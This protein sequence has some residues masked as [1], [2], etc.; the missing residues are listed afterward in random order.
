MSKIEDGIS[1]I[2]INI[3]LEWKFIKETTLESA[4]SVLKQ[5]N[6]G[7]KWFDD[8]CRDA[9]ESKNI[10]RQKMLQIYSRSN[11]EDYES[12]H[13]MAN[14]TTRRKQVFKLTVQ[15]HTYHPKNGFPM[16]IQRMPQH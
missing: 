5:K 7:N 6:K 9:L 2:N 12:K 16:E 4:N 14:Y 8:K 11:R 3:E 1:K 13:R 10:A 15:A